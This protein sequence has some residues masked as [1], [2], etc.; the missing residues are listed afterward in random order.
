[1]DIWV[2]VVT[3]YGAKGDGIQD[4]TLA[5]NNA[6]SY[7]KSIGGGTLWIPKTSAYY[8]IKGEITLCSNLRITSNYAILKKRNYTTANVFVSRSYTNTGYGSGAT[9]VNIEC[10]EFQGDFANSYA[11]SNSLHHARNLTVR[12]CVFNECIAN[13]HS[14]DLAGC[15][16]ITIENCTWYGSKLTTDREYVEAIQIDHSSYLSQP[17]VANTDTYDGLPTMNL[18]VQN[19]KFLPLVKGSVTYPAPNPMGNHS[20][21]KDITYSNIRFLNN[22]VEGGTNTNTWNT[23]TKGWLHFYHAH[24]ITIENN[25][26]INTNA[27]IACPISFLAYDSAHTIDQINDTA[28]PSVSYVPQPCKNISI[29][30]NTFKGFSN[31]GA[32][33]GLIK[34]EGYTNPFDSTAVYAENVKIEDNT[35]VDCYPATVTTTQDQGED[36]IYLTQV[37]DARVAFNYTKNFRRLIYV[38][39][40]VGVD[41]SHNQGENGYWH[42][43]NGNYNTSLNISNNTYNHVSGAF[44]IQNTTGLSICDNTIYDDF[45][46][47]FSTNLIAVRTCSRFKVRGNDLNGNT[48]SPYTSISVYASSSKGIV[49]NNIVSGFSPITVSSDT[50]NTINSENI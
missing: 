26:F 11:S 18:T 24:D 23:H 37:K 14:F 39:Y 10:I 32:D 22:Y 38:T 4:D 16:D 8:W 5:F 40:S 17:S 34:V 1:M 2:N 33:I 20:R 29:K 9:N 44:Y 35:F 27:V 48:N 42:P 3:D 30:N 7:L 12:G 15:R 45:G 6:I 28:P 25:T 46:T 31:V 19:C 36:L 41:V 49:K 50:T 47:S 13:S 43:V 21:W